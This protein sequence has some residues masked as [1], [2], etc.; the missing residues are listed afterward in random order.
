MCPVQ[1]CLAFSL[2]FY[3]ASVSSHANR[4]HLN[5]FKNWFFTVADSIKNKINSFEYQFN[6]LPPVSFESNTHYG[7]LSGTWKIFKN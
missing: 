1:I 4:S 7:A 2:L 3:S 6:M 5:R